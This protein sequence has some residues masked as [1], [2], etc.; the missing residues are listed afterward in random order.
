MYP[1]TPGLAVLFIMDFFLIFK[2]PKPTHYFFF[3]SKNRRT[4]VVTLGA[5]FQHRHNNIT[6][7]PLPTPFRPTYKITLSPY[8]NLLENGMN[9]V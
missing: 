6:Y 3:N 7:P 8:E 2:N 1:N 9:V 4:R 5:F